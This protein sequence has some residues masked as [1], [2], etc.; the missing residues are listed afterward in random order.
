M[1]MALSTHAFLLLEDLS[2]TSCYEQP[3]QGWTSRKYSWSISVLRLKGFPQ[4]KW[5]VF[6]FLSFHIS[7][8]FIKIP[9]YAHLSLLF[10][11]QTIFQHCA[12]S[13][14]TRKF[15]YITM[16][17]HLIMFTYYFYPK[18]KFFFFN[19]QDWEKYSLH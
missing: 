6:C 15:E 19:S 14:W 16:I 18:I 11:C 4:I 13:L 2:N 10:L 12:N 5:C 17:R 9:F 7:R 1:S 8:Y 3:L